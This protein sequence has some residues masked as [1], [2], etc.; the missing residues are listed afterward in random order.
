MSCTHT[1][2]HTN[3]MHTHRRVR[4]GGADAQGNLRG[5]DARG[6]C[7][8]AAP[9]QEPCSPGVCTCV[10]I[11]VRVRVLCSYL[12]TLH[13]C[14]GHVCMC[15]YL[16]VCCQIT[17]CSTSNKPYPTS[18]HVY[19]TRSDVGST[20]NKPILNLTNRALCIV[21]PPKRL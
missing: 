16:Y 19:Y 10:C 4:L 17:P 7:R 13:T 20:S 6:W 14:G 11:R 9:R 5:G 3:H 1:H 12:Y 18:R 21:K 8:C 15:I 2:A